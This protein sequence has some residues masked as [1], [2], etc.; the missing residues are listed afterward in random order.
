[1]LT[2]KD[3]DYFSRVL[4][5]AVPVPRNLIIIALWK[6]AERNGDRSDE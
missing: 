6:V 3:T 1:M 2:V 4:C 5:G